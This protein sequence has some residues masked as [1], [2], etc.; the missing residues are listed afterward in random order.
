VQEI[1]KG[2]TIGRPHLA[3]AMLERGYI[4]TFRE[5]FA[6]YIGRDGPAYAE[7]EKIKP[8]EAVQLI[9][10]AGGIPVLAHPTTAE[11][12]EDS[13]V[14]LKEVGLAGIETYYANYSPEE[15]SRM[16]DIARKY[17]LVATGGS[18]FHGVD[19]TNEPALGSVN[20]PEIVGV[21]LLALAEKQG[22]ATRR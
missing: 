15:I 20:V 11:N 2:G 19:T 17:D 13:V 7:R 21:Q 1:A 18:D 4:T 22:I 10:K 8:V 12:P 9:V 16:L 6:K 14:E 3:Q 5:A